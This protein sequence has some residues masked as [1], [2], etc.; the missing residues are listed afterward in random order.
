MLGFLLLP[1]FHVFWK[2]KSLSNCVGHLSTPD[3]S[4]L[5]DR[6]SFVYSST[7]NEKNTTPRL[8]WIVSVLD[9]LR[10][11]TCGLLKSSGRLAFALFRR[12]LLLEGLG[13]G[14]LLSSLI[15]IVLFYSSSSLLSSP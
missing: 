5:Q 14:Q 7:I 9:L 8:F 10:N 4:T 15:L 1:D 13:R 6:V 11:L 12:G 2:E 3:T